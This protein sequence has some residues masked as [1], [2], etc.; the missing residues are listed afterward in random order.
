M[1]LPSACGSRP[2]H[3]EVRYAD[4]RAA[5]DDGAVGRG[6]L[7]RFIPDSAYQIIER[8]NRK[9]NEIWLFFQKD[10][11]DKKSIIDRCD[12]I[13]LSKVVWP[14]GNPDW[15]PLGLRQVNQD[16]NDGFLPVR[17]CEMP[18]KMAGA[19]FRRVGFL[20]MDSAGEKVWY[21]ENKL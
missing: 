1:G 17:R 11:D 10:K 6:W 3:A 8:H 13:E 9:T 20:S 19:K 16:E 14:E 5:G 7:P 12:P 15:W 18:H 4:M 2:D 21:W